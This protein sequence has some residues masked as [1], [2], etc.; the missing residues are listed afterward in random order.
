[1]AIIIHRFILLGA[2]GRSLIRVGE[3]EGE[4]EEMFKALLGAG[5]AVAERILMLVRWWLRVYVFA[6][7]FAPSFSKH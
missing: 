1:M 3:K 7:L 6:P 5:V 2:R 4:L